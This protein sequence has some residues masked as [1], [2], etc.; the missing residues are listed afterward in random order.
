MMLNLRALPDGLES[1]KEFLK[2]EVD[3]WL[4]GRGKLEEADVTFICS[5]VDSDNEETVR[6][7]G[8]QAVLA[9]VSEVL[10]EMFELASC[11][12]NRSMVH[13]TMDCDPQ[14]RDSSK[15]KTELTSVWQ[16]LQSILCL[17]YKGKTYLSTSAVEKMKTVVKM[18]GLKFP[19]GFDR[20]ILAK[21]SSPASSQTF[22]AT[23]PRSPLTPQAPPAP[24]SPPAPPA[25]RSQSR[26][27]ARSARKRSRTNSAETAKSSG[28]KCRP[29]PSKVSAT[30]R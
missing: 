9:P 17:I 27:P 29:S 7:S 28:K 13:I 6:L 21:N 25:N 2:E 8:H 18:L 4:R 12:H 23:E 22:R 5:S 10:R 19:G 16:V 26:S 14:V 15:Y 20:Q 30:D 24:P 11:S 3:S 1:H